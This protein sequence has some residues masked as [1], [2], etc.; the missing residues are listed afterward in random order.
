MR[1]TNFHV[2]LLQ[3]N[4]FFGWQRELHKRP[5]RRQLHAVVVHWPLHEHLI[6]PKPPTALF[7]LANVR[8]L[9]CFMRVH[10]VSKLC[11]PIIVGEIHTKDKYDRCTAS[12]NTPTSKTKM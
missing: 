1:Q 10:D 12:F 5:A 11:K 3:H 7:A 6:I 9:T 8:V 2:C 4:E